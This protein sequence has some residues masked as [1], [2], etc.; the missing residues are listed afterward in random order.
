MQA[1]AVMETYE[2]PFIARKNSAKAYELW[3]G[4]EIFL[5][6]KTRPEIML[7]ALMIMKNSV[8]FHYFPIYC[9]PELKEQLPADLLKKLKGKTCFHFKKLEP[10]IDK[11]IESALKLGHAAYKKQ[12]WI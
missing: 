1:K 10:A 11:Q 6:G 9:L 8:A 4:K 2:P 5:A 12:G 7:A 3:T